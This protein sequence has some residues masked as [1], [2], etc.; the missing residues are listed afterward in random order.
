MRKHYKLAIST[1]TLTHNNED[2]DINLLEQRGRAREG[3]GLASRESE[4]ERK[5]RSVVNFCS[6]VGFLKPCAM[7]TQRTGRHWARWTPLDQEGAHLWFFLLLPR[8]SLSP[9]AISCPVGA[10]RPSIRSSCRHS[11]SSFQNSK[12]RPHFSL[13]AHHVAPHSSD[14]QDRSFGGTCN[15]QIGR[16]ERNARHGMLVV[17]TTS[18]ASKGAAAWMVDQTENLNPGAKTF[19][20][21]PHRL[22]KAKIWGGGGGAGVLILRDPPSSVSVLY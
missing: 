1:T 4:P 5:Q 13:T 9:I 18:Q 11:R 20:Y 14:T 8:G 22:Q 6:C 16:L 21:I 7:Y 15:S 17:T 10:R 19:R 2:H 12:L 3:G